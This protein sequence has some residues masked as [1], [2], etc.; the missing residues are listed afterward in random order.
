MC[1]AA[2]AS[3]SMTPNGVFF[4]F[5]SSGQRHFA[6][7][8]SLHCVCSGH[9]WLAVALNQWLHIV[10]CPILLHLLSKQSLRVV[11]HRT[12]SV[13]AILVSTVCHAYPAHT[14]VMPRGCCTCTTARQ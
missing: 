11:A 5:F 3:R 1:S 2:A 14:K 13:V 10:L 4:L 9:F 7:G 8:S 12:V 6:I